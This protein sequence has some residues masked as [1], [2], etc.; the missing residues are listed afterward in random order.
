VDAGVSQPMLDLGVLG[1]QAVNCFEHWHSP[2]S[3]DLQDVIPG[4]CPGDQV[5]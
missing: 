4:G 2:F 5:V 3:D 1:D